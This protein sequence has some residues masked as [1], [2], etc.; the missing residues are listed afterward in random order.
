MWYCLLKKLYVKINNTICWRGIEAWST[1]KDSRSSYKISFLL[2]VRGFESHPLHIFNNYAIND[3][4]IV[5]L[6]LVISLWIFEISSFLKDRLHLKH[7][8]VSLGMEQ[9]VSILILSSCII[10]S[11][12]RLSNQWF[13]YFKIRWFVWL[14]FLNLY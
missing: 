5:I 6:W 8:H 11:C 1:E 3:F 2:G 9:K 14:I 12:S 7:F 10:C 13:R 4:I